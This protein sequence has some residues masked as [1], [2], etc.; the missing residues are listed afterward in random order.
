MCRVPTAVPRL[1]GSDIE[2]H[3]TTDRQPAKLVSQSQGVRLPWRHQAIRRPG[4]A[5]AAFML[6]MLFTGGA[7]TLGD[8]SLRE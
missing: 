5:L 3:H 7:G 4:G 1:A 6:R 2:D 8:R